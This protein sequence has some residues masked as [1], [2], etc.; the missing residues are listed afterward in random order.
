[1]KKLLIFTVVG[2]LFLTACG[3]KKDDVSEV[4]EENS[5]FTE[6]LDELI[7]EALDPSDISI[8]F[9][10]IDPDKY[11]IVREPYDLGFT[12]KEDYEEYAA[13][14]TKLIDELSEFKDADLSLNQQMDR[15]ALIDEFQRSLELSKYYDF[16]VGTSILGFA[17]SFM[18]S[19]PAYLEK[20][21][22]HDLTDVE[23]YLNF[24]DTLAA[25]FQ[26]YV[27]LEI[28][29][30][31]RGT[32]YSKAELDEI[33]KQAKSLSEAALNNEFYLVEDFNVKL[34]KT[35]LDNKDAL[36]KRN[37]TSLKEG[38]SVAFDTIVKGLEG[39]DADEPKGLAHKPD[40]KEYY[41]AL[42]Q[43]NTG[44]SR[45]I[46]EIEKLVA[47]HKTTNSIAIQALVKD[48]PQMESFFE[49]YTKGP[50][51]KQTT[52]VELIDFLNSNYDKY[53][54]KTGDFNYELRKVNESMEEGSSPAFYF[55]PQIDYSDEYK[56]V[57]YVKGD[58][59][60]SSYKTYGHEST[61]GHMYQFTYFLNSEL[62]PIRN[63]FTS[64]ANAEGWAKYSEQYVDRIIGMDKDQ[65]EFNRAYDSIVQILHIEMDIGINY[66]GW[67][68]AEFSKFIGENFGIE[69][70]AMLDEIYLNFVHNPGAYP[71]YYLSQLYIE[72]L[73]KSYFQF[74]DDITLDKEFHEA[75]F[76][77]GSTG[78]DVIEKGFK[79]E[80][81]K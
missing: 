53:F 79:K 5:Q 55:T 35:D 54:P 37:Q 10:F 31:E 23:G 17:R 81:K 64:S 26:E 68:M 73:K 6:Y 7:L 21:E 13:D 49:N 70:E 80:L 78:F 39:I 19:V 33:V 11:G 12:S 46:D 56:Q 22:F 60:P 15:D 69:D 61:P 20:Y 62:H 72:D 29:R 45:T 63:I 77:Y 36:K 3:N 47:K 9:T 71:T 14:L 41:L 43:S 38:F 59:D 16:E 66:K 24:M 67:D 51:L 65:V 42:L 50:E 28:D 48:Q 2:L 30:Q 40:G 57:I 75:F 18:G 74:H 52:G 34:D 76:K 32:G 27:N 1:M 44:S 58:F 4:G 8:N 25:S